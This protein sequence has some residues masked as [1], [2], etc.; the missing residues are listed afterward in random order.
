[1]QVRQHVW[2]GL[3]H[4]GHLGQGKFFL[5]LGVLLFHALDEEVDIFYHLAEYELQFG[6]RDRLVVFEVLVDA[7]VNDF[8][9]ADYILQDLHYL[10]HICLIFLLSHLDEKSGEQI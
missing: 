10:L 2:R 9:G 3:Q 6:F 7:F 1:M 8:V 4:F 5:V